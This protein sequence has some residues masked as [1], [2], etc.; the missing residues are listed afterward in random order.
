[1]ELQ[2]LTNPR[3]V[4]ERYRVA[5]AEGRL[6]QKT[7]HNTGRD[8]RWLACALG[9]IGENV[10][11]PDSCPASVM[12]CWLARKVPMLFDRQDICDAREWGLRFYTALADVAGDVPF[13]AVHYWHAHTVCA[14]AI[15]ATENMD[16]NAA[17]HKALR[18]MHL[19]AL[20]GESIGTD[21]WRSV[22]DHFYRR[23]DSKAFASA[24]AAADGRAYATAWD[25]SIDCAFGFLF[26]SAIY[27]LQRIWKQMADGLVDAIVA[28]G[29]GAR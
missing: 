14:V 16:L 13:S 5:L 3:D 29:G 10:E 27:G 26:P 11:S 24:Y 2:L 17:P 4:L 20:A 15:D 9:V 23:R 7:W 22:L 19:R 1:M 6:I 28:T 18:D 8:G 25:E 12:P 21:E